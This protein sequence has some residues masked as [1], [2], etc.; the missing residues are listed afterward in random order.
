MAIA[1]KLTEKTVSL[2]GDD[3]VENIKGVDVF[4]YL[5]RLLD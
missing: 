5:G 1:N 4:N 3:R 2:T